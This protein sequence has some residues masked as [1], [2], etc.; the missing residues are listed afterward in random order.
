MINLNLHKVT[1]TAGDDSSLVECLCISTQH[2]KK[3]MLEKKIQ[4]F[5]ANDP[6][7]IQKKKGST[8][9]KQGSIILHTQCCSMFDLL[10]TSKR[11]HVAAFTKHSRAAPRLIYQSISGSEGQKS[12][13]LTRPPRDSDV[14]SV[15]ILLLQSFYYEKS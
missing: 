9:W 8:S 12:E 7:I 5:K 11:S 15:S 14:Y 10:T 4:A 13:M 3:H 1:E 6:L 2:K